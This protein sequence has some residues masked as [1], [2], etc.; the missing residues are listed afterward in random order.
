MKEMKTG[1]I[2][3]TGLN[4]LIFRINEIFEEGTGGILTGGHEGDEN[5]RAGTGEIG[6]TDE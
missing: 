6:R 2:Q 3:N 4:F 1:G 5:R